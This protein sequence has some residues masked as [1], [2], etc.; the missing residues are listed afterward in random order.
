L[1]IVEGPAADWAATV[2]RDSH[3]P[4]RPTLKHRR[5]RSELVEMESPV[6]VIVSSLVVAA[7]LIALVARLPTDWN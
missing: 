2:I 3:A 5:I 7:V 1:L 6:L 4:Q